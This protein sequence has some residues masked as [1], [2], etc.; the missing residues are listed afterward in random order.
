[1]WAAIRGF[2]GQYEVSTA[3]DIRNVRTG[4]ILKPLKDR[5]GY[6][7]VGLYGRPRQKTDVKIHRAV[8]SAF[9]DNP[10]NWPEVNHLN[11]VRGDNRL[12]NLEWCTCS[13]NRIHSFRVLGRVVGNERA[14]VAVKG[15]E[16]LT[17][18]SMKEAERNGFSRTGM[19]NCINGNYKHHHGYEWRYA[20]GSA[21]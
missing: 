10:S 4:L 20:D 21:C 6:H 15:D 2:E 3:G 5:D 7:Q 12:E 1:M 18:S 9:L 14:L 16:V 19:Y 17:F 8:A 11:G 13:M